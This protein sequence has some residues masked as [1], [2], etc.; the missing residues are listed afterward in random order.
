MLYRKSL[1]HTHEIVFSLVHYVL[2]VLLTLVCYLSAIVA[3][4]VE[5]ALC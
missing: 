3:V 5:D 4:S 2:P 1:S